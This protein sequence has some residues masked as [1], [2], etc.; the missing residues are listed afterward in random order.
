MPR[1]FVL[2]TPRALF[3]V[4]ALTAILVGHQQ[5]PSTWAQILHLNECELPCWI[6]IIPGQTT[7]TEAQ[8][9]LERVYGDTSVYQLKDIGD[10][11]YKVSFE[12]TGES[13]HI[14]FVSGNGRA[15][16]NSVITQLYLEPF[17]DQ[18][19]FNKRL[20]I[21]DLYEALGKP[22]I[23]RLIFGLEI[24]RIAILTKGQRVQI[25]LDNIECDK[26]YINQE[27]LQ[28]RFIESVPSTGNAWL[29]DPQQWRGFG[30]CYHFERK[31]FHK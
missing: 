20:T 6:G 5:Q 18:N 1:F 22:E 28:I 17:L 24:E 31:L 2:L 12:A 21:P 23:V 11:G 10:S 9:E 30:R 4:F 19:S 14:V 13:L 8:Q 25:F 29:S 3:F 16:Q 15:T 7:L 27:I 26:L